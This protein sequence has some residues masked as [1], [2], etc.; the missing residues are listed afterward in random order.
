MQLPPKKGCD[1]KNIKI[2]ALLSDGSQAQ[3]WFWWGLKEMVS[4]SI[5]LRDSQKSL[6]LLNSRIQL[7]SYCIQEKS[8][9]TVVL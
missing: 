8:Y 6:H 1:N 7:Q 3:K 9:I 2:F 5:I 4:L